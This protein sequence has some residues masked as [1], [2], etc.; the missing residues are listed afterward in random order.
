MTFIATVTPC[1]AYLLVALLQDTC[2]TPSSKMSGDT[3]PFSFNDALVTPEK[4]ACPAA[5][6]ACAEAIMQQAYTS[7]QHPH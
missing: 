4:N 1:V 5:K 7:Q 2:V 6:V 3:H